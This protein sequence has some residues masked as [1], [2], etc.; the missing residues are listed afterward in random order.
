MIMARIRRRLMVPFV[1]VKSV[2]GYGKVGDGRIEILEL[3]SVLT[4]ESFLGTK[5]FKEEY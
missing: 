4:A 3:T 5:S 1:E 2:Y